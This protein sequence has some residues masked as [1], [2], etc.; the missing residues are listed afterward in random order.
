MRGDNILDLVFATNDGLVSNVNTRLE[1]ST[2]D[3]K[4]VSFNINLEAYKENV[5]VE[6]IYVR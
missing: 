1:F 2:S 3:H 6:L 4:T 5:S